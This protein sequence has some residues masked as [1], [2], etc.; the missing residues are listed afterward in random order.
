MLLRCQERLHYR[1][2]ER[3][4]SWPNSFVSILS[5]GLCPALIRDEATVEQQINQKQIKVLIYNSQNT[6]NNIQALINLAQAKYIPVA[7]LTET[8]TPQNASFQDWQSKQLEGLQT[9]LAQA[10]GKRS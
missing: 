1:R 4:I 10:T 3:D 9:A 2:C 5:R 6:P 7:T 8:L